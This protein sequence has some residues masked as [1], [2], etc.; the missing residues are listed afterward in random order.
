MGLK[1]WKGLI[2][3]ERGTGEAFQAKGTM[4]VKTQ[5]Q[6]RNGHMWRTD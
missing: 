6:E 2:K 4:W 5:K 1:K 3:E